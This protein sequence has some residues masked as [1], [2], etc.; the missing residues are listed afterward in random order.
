[1][2]VGVLGGLERRQRWSQDDKA[3]IVEETLMPGAKVTELRAATVSRPTFSTVSTW[4][5]SK[6]RFAPEAVARK[7]IAFYAKP[8]QLAN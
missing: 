1:M 2:R 5:T 3:R 8:Y 6:G 7:L 4:L